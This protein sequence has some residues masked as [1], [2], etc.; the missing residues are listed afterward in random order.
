MSTSS[1]T[2]LAKMGEKNPSRVNQGLKTQRV[3]C[4]TMRKLAETMEN[5][6]KENNKNVL[7]DRQLKEN[8]NLFFEV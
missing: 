4:L 8:N 6:H 1:L 5:C 2:K 3:K 7:I